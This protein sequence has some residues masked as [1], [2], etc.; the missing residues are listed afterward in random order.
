MHGNREARDIEYFREL[1][2]LGLP[3]PEDVKKMVELIQSI[4]NEVYRLKDLGDDINQIEINKSMSFM[5]VRV[6][7]LINNYHR[8]PHN[9]IGE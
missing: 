8:D 7:E 4:S 9:P 5:I 1:Q 3:K 2:R 6:S